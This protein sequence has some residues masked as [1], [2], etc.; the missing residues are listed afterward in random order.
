MKGSKVMLEMQKRQLLN[1]RRGK[2]RLLPWKNGRPPATPL[3]P[4]ESVLLNSFFKDMD[5]DFACGRRT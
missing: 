1:I 3:L 2:M 4:E 5:A